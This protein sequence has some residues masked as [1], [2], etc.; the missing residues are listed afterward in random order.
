MITPG[1]NLLKYALKAIKPQLVAWHKFKSRER[2]ES[3]DFVSSYEPVRNI[4]GSFQTVPRTMYQQMNLD[5]TSAYATFY[6]AE[7]LGEVK[8]GEGGDQVTFMGS[9]YQVVDNNDWYQ[10]DGWVG[11]LLVQIGDKNAR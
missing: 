7:P 9:R 6:T 5:W 4:K 11:V 2:N 1:S 3:G 10:I 8:K